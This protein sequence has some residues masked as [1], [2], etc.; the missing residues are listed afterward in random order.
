MFLPFLKS[1]HN[2]KRKF[3]DG[4]LDKS[5]CDALHNLR[6]TKKYALFNPLYQ[7]AE[8]LKLISQETSRRP[9]DFSSVNHFL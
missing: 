2:Y 4:T 8:I 6:T 1:L 5:H 7:P 3:T 9:K